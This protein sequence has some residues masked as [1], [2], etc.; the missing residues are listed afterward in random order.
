ME[1]KKQNY[2]QCIFS[3]TIDLETR[4]RSLSLVWIVDPKHGY[5]NARIEKNRLNNIREKANV[6]GFRK[7]VNYFR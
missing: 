7:Q 2:L 6:R 1:I 4:S 5:N 3:H